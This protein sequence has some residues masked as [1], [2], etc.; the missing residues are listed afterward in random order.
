MKLDFF[1]PRSVP[2]ASIKWM[3]LST[4]WP[5]MFQVMYYSSQK[6]AAEHPACHLASPMDPKSRTMRRSQG[7]CT[8]TLSLS[9]A[10]PRTQLLRPAKLTE[11]LSAPSLR[12]LPRLH[13]SQIP[14]VLRRE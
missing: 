13:S 11:S 6:T 5:S 7:H 10:S 14:Q 1:N 12:S 8:V 4:S 9:S 3:R 2:K